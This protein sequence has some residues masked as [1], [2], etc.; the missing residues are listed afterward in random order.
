VKASLKR[1]GVTTS[2][3]I[4]IGPAPIIVA[5]AANCCP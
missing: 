4:L 2:I 5:V 1:G 3:L